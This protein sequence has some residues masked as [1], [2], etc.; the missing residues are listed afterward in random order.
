VPHSEVENIVAVAL[1]V[2][3]G[4]FLDVDDVPLQ[5]EAERA[6][7]NRPRLERGAADAVVAECGVAFPDR[8]DLIVRGP[9]SW[10]VS[11]GR[12]DAKRQSRRAAACR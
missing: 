7:N 10:I 12:V 2:A 5:A 8:K 6:A 4:K 1:V 9:V 11:P 3:A